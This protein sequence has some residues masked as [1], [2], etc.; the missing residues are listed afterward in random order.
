MKDHLP[1]PACNVLPNAAWDA[2][3]LPSEHTDD[4][5][6]SYYSEMLS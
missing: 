2:V 6:I 1:Q 3:D 4:S 5:F